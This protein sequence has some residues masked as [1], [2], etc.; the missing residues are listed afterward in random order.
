[1][2]G[3]VWY[4]TTSPHGHVYLANYTLYTAAS[5]GFNPPS[6][7]IFAGNSAEWVMERPGVNGGLADLTNYNGLAD[8][9]NVDYAYNGS[10]YFYPAS[11][12][13]VYTDYAIR[14][15]CPPWN[16]SSSCSSQTVIST[17]DLYGLYT[18]WFYDSVP[19]Y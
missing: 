18:L 7:T 6:G 2:L 13:S 10:N 19:A 3:E 14:M 16:P 11:V 9:Y 4:T 12:P 1:M 8:A 17:P 15:V 5:Y